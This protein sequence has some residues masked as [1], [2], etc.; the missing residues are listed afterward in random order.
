MWE[1]LWKNDILPV[2]HRDRRDGLESGM[3][4]C[5]WETGE[6]ERGR[7]CWLLARAVT[8]HSRVYLPHVLCRVPHHRFE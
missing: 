2:S 7:V 4:V 6:Q 8:D 3:R 5:T 1:D